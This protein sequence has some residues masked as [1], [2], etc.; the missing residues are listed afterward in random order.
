[1]EDTHTGFISTL[2]PFFRPYTGRVFLALLALIS[3]AAASLAM[4]IVVRWMVDDGFLSQNPEF[5]RQYFYAF[6]GI[7]IALAVFAAARFYLVTWLAERIIADIRTAIF[8]HVIAMSPAFFEETKTG[9]VLSRITTDTTLVQSAVGPGFSIAL[10]STIMLIGGLIML[11]ITHVGLTGIILVIVPLVLFPLFYFGKK[12]RHLSRESQACIAESSAIA[13]ETLNGIQMIQSFT[14]EGLLSKKFDQAVQQSFIAGISRNRSRALL[15]AFAIMI[16]FGAILVVLWIGTQLVIEG[17]LTTGELSQFL[18]YAILVATS[19]AAVSDVWGDV[20][21]A[22]GA[23]ERLME[24]LH[25]ESDIDSVKT[26]RLLPTRDVGG[27]TFE[28]VTFSYPSRPD[29]YALKNFSFT[30]HPGETIALVGPSG[31]GKSTVL[32]LLL[33]FYDPQEGHILVGDVDSTH[34]GLEVLRRSVGFVPQQ[35]VIFAANAMENIRYGKP[36][37]SDNEVRAA[38]KAAFAD[39]FIENQPEGYLTFLG[40]R[41]IRLSGGQQQ[42]IAVARA[43][44]KNSPIMLLDEATS[45]LD[46]ESERLVQEA[47]DNLLEDRTTLVI[48][49]RLATVLKADRIVVMEK[50]EIVAVGTHQELVRQGGLYARLAK[51]QFGVRS[52]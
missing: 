11:S 33:R 9:E 30:I 31:A 29:Y 32:Q 12:V 18:L 44:L 48:A 34:I 43:L 41:G 42:R 25:A 15:T 49:H 37:A 19:T 1:M 3:A 46:A 45:A 16:V 20:Q 39:E 50:G 26:P 28:N 40:E 27:V 36:D 5:I 2:I 10:R 17:R 47:L 52:N 21:K 24:L 23:M 22:V 4:P 8:Q 14:L 38:A 35:T 51:L 7:V 6:F 13:S